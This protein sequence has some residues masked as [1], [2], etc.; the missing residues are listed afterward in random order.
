M[1]QINLLPWREQ[2]RQQKRKEFGYTVGA[3]VA[4]TIV[5]IILTHIHYTNKIKSE[6]KRNAF[7]TAEVGK[8]NQALLSLN[9]QVKEGE[10][11]DAELHFL[12]S[13]REKSY[14][15]VSLLDELA[16]V[17]PEAVTLTQVIRQGTTI[18]ISGNALSDYQITLLMKNMSK[19]PN[20]NQPDLNQINASNDDKNSGTLFQIKVTQKESRN[21]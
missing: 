15:A 3:L 6:I 8:E 18:T 1:I 4:L 21:P 20:F 12:M 2:A 17:I 10:L 9:D 5:F 11:V 19:S 7:L 16:R 13:L 14:Q